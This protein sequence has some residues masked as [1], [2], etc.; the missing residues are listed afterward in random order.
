MPDQVALAKM[1]N[2][3]FLVKHM[4]ASLQHGS[5][6]RNLWVHIL[7]MMMTYGMVINYS[8]LMFVD[9]KYQYADQ[10]TETT[11]SKGGLFTFLEFVYKVCFWS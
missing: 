7:L 8:S 2:R 4:L 3:K 1:R 11:E 9:C 5:Q 10:R 6:E